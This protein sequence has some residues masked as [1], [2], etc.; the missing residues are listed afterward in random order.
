MEPLWE[1][2]LHL[3]DPSG[4]LYP[5][6][7]AVREA[8]PR[9]LCSSGCTI[10][11]KV[12]LSGCTILPKVYL[13]GCVTRCILLRVCT[14]VYTSQGVS[15]LPVY[16]RVCLSYWCTSGWY[17]PVSLLVLALVLSV[18][19]LMW[20]LNRFCSRVDIPVS[21]FGIT[22]CSLF[23]QVFTFW[24]GISRYMGPVSRVWTAIIM[25]ER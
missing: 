2:I 9:L 8:I 20:V 23:S 5:A 1:A 18:P 21:L 13:S 14:T 22:F 11:P 16:L 10:L 12:D 4:K 7:Y 6:C 25:P 19:G 17:P 3:W 15:L 24:L